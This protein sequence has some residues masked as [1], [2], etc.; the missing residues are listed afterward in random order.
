ML[1]TLAATETATRRAAGEPIAQAVNGGYHLAYV[2]GAGLV[3]VAIVIALV[4]LEPQPRPKREHAR[5]RAAEPAC[6]AA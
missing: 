4:V 6:E 2:I 1:A 3:A 5:M